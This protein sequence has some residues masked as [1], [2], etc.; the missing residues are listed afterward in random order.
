MKCAKK[1]AFL[2]T[3]A[4]TLF[5]MTPFA[6][7]LQG[8]TSVGVGAANTAQIAPTAFGFWGPSLRVGGALHLGEFLRVTLDG[9][10][11]FH[12]GVLDAE[13]SEGIDTFHVAALAIGLRYDLDIITYVPY[14][15]LSFVAYP[16][17]VPRTPE[18]GEPFGLRATIGLDYRHSRFWSW[19]GS[20][21]LATP[22]SEP[23]D[24]PLYSSLHFHLC[25]HFR[26]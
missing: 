24:F 2:F 26:L 15:G 23:G 25:Y 22:L 16:L 1:T 10:Y 18:A 19:G 11:S 5:A 9:Q 20:V 21:E 8:Q 13:I 12:R 7:A 6:F 4:L 14:L 3:F 17:Q